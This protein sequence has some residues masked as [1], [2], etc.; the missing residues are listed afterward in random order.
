MGRTRG[1]RKGRM[2]ESNLACKTT[3]RCSRHNRHGAMTS[4]EAGVRER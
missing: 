2:N 3:R 1:V 4:Q